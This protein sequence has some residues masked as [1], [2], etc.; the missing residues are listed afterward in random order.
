[1]KPKILL[2]ILFLILLRPTFNNIPPVVTNTEASSVLVQTITT[3]NG[4]DSLARPFGID[5]NGSL[6]AVAD[7]FRGNIFFFNHQNQYLATF[8]VSS[9]PGNFSSP[10]DVVLTDQHIGVV[11]YTNNVVRIF[12]TNGNY[13]FSL[14]NGTNGNSTEELNAPQ[15]IAANSTHFFIA[16]TQNDRVQIFT[17]G[18]SYAGSIP[19]SLPTSV[20]INGTYIFVVSSGS[21]KVIIYNSDGSPA[22]FSNIGSGTQAGVAPGVMDTP[23]DISFDPVRNFIYVTEIQNARVSI[24]ALNPNGV[25]FDFVGYV[26][27]Q[28]NSGY[29]DAPYGVFSNGTHVYVTIWHPP[30][31]GIVQIYK[32]MEGDVVTSTVTQTNTVDN[33]VT[34]HETQLNTINNTVTQVNNFTD[35]TTKVETQ[36]TTVYSE[37]TIYQPTTSTKN[38]SPMSTLPV[39]IGLFGLMVIRMTLLRKK[40]KL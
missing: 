34:Q 2:I 16:D 26:G 32:I 37:T 4:T 14:G 7:M 38:G 24:F 3:Y 27:Y 39:L 36:Q 12:D 19:V 40:Q 29:L 17:I 11:A 31:T 9:G 13:Q 25:T 22:S 18:G 6:F 30:V 33:T 5:N 23:H 20:A 1:M 15:G 21:H 8:N 35:T 10:Y 28:T